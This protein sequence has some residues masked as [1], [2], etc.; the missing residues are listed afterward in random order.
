MKG[1]QFRRFTYLVTS[2]HQSISEI[3]AQIKSEDIQRQLSASAIRA[4][5]VYQKEQ[6]CFLLI[7][8]EPNMTSYTVSQA[9]SDIQGE[10]DFL[11]LFQKKNNTFSFESSAL[12][13]IYKLDQK[14][15]YSPRE[16]QLKNDIGKKKRFVWTLL[17]EE[18]P[19]LIAEYKKVHGIGQGKRYGDLSPRH[20][21]HI[22]HGYKAWFRFG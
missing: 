5:E 12:E 10:V 20:T 22:N 8:A 7:D 21:S 17:L 3:T 14:V 18:D 9:L 4:F 13:R 19:K 15:A 6:D 2:E 11:L 1:N 16:G